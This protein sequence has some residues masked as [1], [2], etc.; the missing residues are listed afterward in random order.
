[1]TRLSR[2]IGERAA[3]HVIVHFGFHIIILYYYILSS[4][5]FPLHP[6]RSSPRR[7]FPRKLRARRKRKKRGSR[8][9]LFFSLS[10]SLSPLSALSLSGDG[11]RGK[12]PCSHQPPGECWI[13]SLSLLRFSLLSHSTTLSLFGFSLLAHSIALSRPPDSLS[14]SS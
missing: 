4:L 8:L 5:T 11:R 13:Y 10:C 7:S 1:M 9:V 3:S 6:R 12:M 2:R 14:P